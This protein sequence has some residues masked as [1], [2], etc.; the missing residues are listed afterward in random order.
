MTV[1]LFALKTWPIAT[2]LLMIYSYPDPEKVD[3]P[4]VEEKKPLAVSL[5]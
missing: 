2:I 1:S 3:E 4:L 5:V